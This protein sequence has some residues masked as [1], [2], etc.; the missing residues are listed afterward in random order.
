MLQTD[1]P[2]SPWLPLKSLKKSSQPSISYQ[3]PSPQDK[4]PKTS[5]D[6][7]LTV[8]GA[9]LEMAASVSLESLLEVEFHNCLLWW[10]L[11]L[12]VV[13]MI[14][15]FVQMEVIKIQVTC[16][17]LLPWEPTQSWSDDWLQVANKVL[18][19]HLTKMEDSLK[20]SEGWLDVTFYFKVVGANISKM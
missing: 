20:C 15:L 9:V 17:K 1:I 6:T 7:V 12:F 16:A 11:L 10:I 19:L 5:L 18:V 14:F 2:N 3:G 8:S 4:V 13:T